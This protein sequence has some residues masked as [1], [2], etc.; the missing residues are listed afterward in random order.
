M[1]A[2]RQADGRAARVTARTEALACLG[3]HP[4][5][6]PRGVS[7]SLA[8]LLPTL[9]L[10]VLSPHQDSKGSHRLSRSWPD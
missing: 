3:S 7:E 5:G 4:G 10:A 2:D 8:R 6:T 9:T 1:A